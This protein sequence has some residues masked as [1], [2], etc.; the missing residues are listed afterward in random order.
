MRNY[1]KCFTYIILLV[2]TII[3]EVDTHPHFMD[4]ETKAQRGSEYSTTLCA[5]IRT[6]DLEDN[7]GEGAQGG[8]KVKNTKWVKTSWETHPHRHTAEW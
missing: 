4:E 8:S 5:M 3:Y 7:L 6:L 2:Y 1:A